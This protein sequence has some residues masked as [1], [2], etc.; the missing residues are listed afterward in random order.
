[1]SEQET[2]FTVEIEETTATVEAGTPLAVT[3]AV[4]NDGADGSA[5]V[6]L[7]DF[8]GESVASDE[9][10]LDGGEG[11]TLELS[12]TPGPDAVGDGDITVETAGD[13]A[14]ESVTVQDAPAAFEVS[15]DAPE[16]VPEG[17]T[18]TVVADVENTGTLEGSQ[19][20]EFT[21]DE[22]R[23][24]GESVTLAGQE[25][26]QLEY[27][28]AEAEPPELTVEVS[29]D[30]DSA[31]ASV[32]VVTESVS[33]VRPVRSKGGMGIFGWIYFLGMI[34]LLFPLL[35]LLAILKLVDVLLGDDSPVR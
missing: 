21:V 14:T 29:S 3:V 1:M 31:S 20:I 7:L 17:D 25:Q 11:E 12:W 26:A 30:D 4:E 13:S 19:E 35:P 32:P 24:K 34:A 5:A 8:D 6:E 2:A 27:E 28:T 23:Q 15:T 22:E 33:A 16:H 10:E 9:P 18:A